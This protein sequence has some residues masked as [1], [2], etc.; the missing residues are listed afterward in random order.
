[1]Q[2]RAN[3]VIAWCDGGDWGAI[4]TYEI[5]QTAVDVL[6]LDATVKLLTMSEKEIRQVLDEAKA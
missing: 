5:R 4:N 6:M 3:R 1:M 2:E